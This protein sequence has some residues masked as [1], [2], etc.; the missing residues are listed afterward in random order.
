MN[1]IETFQSDVFAEG[2]WK[3]SASSDYA[4][5]SVS[6][7]APEDPAPAFA[8]DLGMN[9]D[10]PATKYGVVSEISPAVETTGQDL[11]IQYELRLQKGLE[12]GGAYLKLLST[13]A[14]LSKFDNNV[15]GSVV[16]SVAVL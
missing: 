5:Q 10:L 2:R 6:T 8:A 7:K 12:C 4:G 14:D 16:F 3:K 1:Y 13:D 9:F 15:R 11:V